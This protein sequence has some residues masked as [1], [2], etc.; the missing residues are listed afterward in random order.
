[1]PFLHLLRSLDV[2]YLLSD[3]VKSTFVDLHTL[4]TMVNDVLLRIVAFIF[5]KDIHP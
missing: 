2:F 5:I 1:M 4:K 3:A